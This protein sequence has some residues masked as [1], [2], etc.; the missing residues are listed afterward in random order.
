MADWLQMFLV[1]A[2]AGIFAYV[3]AFAA[4]RTDI[5]WIKKELTDHTGELKT[6]HSRINALLSKK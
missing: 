3:G 6:L 2:F 4:V 1:P 5:A